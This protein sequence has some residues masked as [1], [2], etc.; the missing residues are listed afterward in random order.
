M[1]HHVYTTL[2]IS[3]PLKPQNL[4]VHVLVNAWV[5]QCVCNIEASMDPYILAGYDFYEVFKTITLVSFSFVFQTRSIFHQVGLR[6]S[7][8]FWRR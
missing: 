3:A 2:S 4:T 6:F 7:L 5:K 1:Y 8:L